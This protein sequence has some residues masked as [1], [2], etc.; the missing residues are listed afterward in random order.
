MRA[1]RWFPEGIGGK[2]AKNGCFQAKNGGKACWWFF[3]VAGVFQ[4]RLVGY[5]S[6]NG[7]FLRKL[8]W[9]WET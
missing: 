5:F 4:K 9:F 2:G 1:G 3:G 7:R 8:K 6:K